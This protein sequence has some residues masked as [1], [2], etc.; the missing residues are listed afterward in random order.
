MVFAGCDL[1]KQTISVCV[2]NQSRSV[3]H[4]ERFACQ[5]VERIREFFRQLGEFEAVVEATAS[6]EWFVQL[7]EPLARR[8]LL[9][10]PKKLRVIA[11]STRKSDRLDAQILA[12]F[13]ALDMIPTS[14]RPT[15]RQRAHR[16][17]VRQRDRIQRR[18]T[19]IKNR[20]RRLLSD[21]NADR[22]RLFNRPGLE[23]LKTLPLPPADR[24]TMDQFL[25]EY[26]FGQQ[27]LRKA[28]LALQTFAKQGT[29]REQEWRVLLRSIPGVGFVTA[30]VIL[31][32]LADVERFQS[33]KQIVAYAGLAPGQRESAGKRQELHIEKEGSRLLRGILVEAAWRLVRHSV[34]WRGIYEKL[35]ARVRAKKAIV[36][37][38]RRLLTLTASILVSGQPYR[39]D[40]IPG[41]SAA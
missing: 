38:A 29:N 31:A 37:V 2:V 28:E 18:L 17:L 25:E 1:H 14:Y 8:V 34:R 33:Q 21:H 4:R 3:L 5:D 19:S 41:G 27:Q 10:H 32:E 36:A 22:L 6:Y 23:F 30:E 11:E 35:K 40:Y 9:A 26:D 20:I 16:R 13:L 39:A 7:L 12:E 24:F 15:P